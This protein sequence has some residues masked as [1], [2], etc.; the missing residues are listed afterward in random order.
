MEKEET[1]LAN[2]DF[3]EPHTVYTKLDGSFL[4]PFMV[5]GKVRFG[6]KMGLTDVALQA[7]PFIAAHP[8]Y[9]AFSTW[10]IENGITPV[11]EYTAPDNR[12]VIHYDKP[13]LTLLACRHMITG[14]YLPL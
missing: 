11:F 10:C 1:Q 12:I 2:V 6:T 4:S 14:E 5:E 13:M 3:S 8:E 7:E 9:L